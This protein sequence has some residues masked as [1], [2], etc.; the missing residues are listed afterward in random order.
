M[1]SGVMMEPWLFSILMD[2]ASEILLI[3]KVTLETWKNTNM[4]TFSVNQCPLKS[5]WLNSLL[6]LDCYS[7]SP[8]LETILNNGKGHQWDEIWICDQL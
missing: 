6:C 4:P 3:L 2:S 1:L 8:L 7:Y 5:E